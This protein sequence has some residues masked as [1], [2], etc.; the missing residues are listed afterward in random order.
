MALFT[1]KVNEYSM[2]WWKA[3]HPSWLQMNQKGKEKVA[4]CWGDLDLDNKS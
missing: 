4:P 1:I 2:L 3:E